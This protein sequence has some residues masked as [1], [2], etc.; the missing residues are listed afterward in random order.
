M[1]K[2]ADLDF[3]ALLATKALDGFM[4]KETLQKYSTSLFSR[5]QK[6]VR[7]MLEVRLLILISPKI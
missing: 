2:Y 4:S 6:E 7:L 3:D 1:Q 5:M